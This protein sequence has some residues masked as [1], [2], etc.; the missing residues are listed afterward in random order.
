MHL[1]ATYA[2]GWLN[3]LLFKMRFHRYHDHSSC[4]SS[5]PRPGLGIVH[6]VEI[7]QLL[8][9]LQTK[10]RRASNA[11]ALRKC[12]RGATLSVWMQFTT[13]AKRALTSLP[14]VMLAITFLTL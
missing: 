6:H 10:H 14:T 3:L 11:A 2:P 4:L 1:E 7:D 13:S 12:H 9:L 8:Q 5:P